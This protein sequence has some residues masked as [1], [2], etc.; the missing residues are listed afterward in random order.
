[1]SYSK[2]N[3]ANEVSDSIASNSF[4]AINFTT[5]HST[6]F[7]DKMFSNAIDSNKISGNL[8]A[9]IFDHLPQFAIIP[10]MFGN[11][12]GNKSNIYERD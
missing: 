7:I 12:S 4:C 2:H 5:I 1:M 10:D 11:I 8:N 3:Q 9:T 6:T